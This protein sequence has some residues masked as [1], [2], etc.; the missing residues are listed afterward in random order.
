M[1]ITVFLTVHML[2]W[3]YL[4]AHDNWMEVMT[5]PRRLPHLRRAALRGERG[6]LGAAAAALCSHRRQ[7]HLGALR[8]H[9]CPLRRIDSLKGLTI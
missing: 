7:Q 1:L 9:P 6:P 2:T 8:A 3:S 5:L 4:H